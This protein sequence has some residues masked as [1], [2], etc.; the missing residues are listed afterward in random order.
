VGNGGFEQ[1]FSQ[2]KLIKTSHCTCLKED[3]LDQLLCRS[4]D[5][6]AVKMMM[7]TLK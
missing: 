7:M 2:L 1:V 5:N 6:L 4:E 3:I